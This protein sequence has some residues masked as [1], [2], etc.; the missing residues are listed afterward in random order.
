[1]NYIYTLLLEKNIFYHTIVEYLIFELK[2]V[3][4][5]ATRKFNKNRVIEIS[6]PRFLDSDYIIVMGTI[7]SFKV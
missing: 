2:T 3:F 6:S 5:D 1:M 4:T 7:L